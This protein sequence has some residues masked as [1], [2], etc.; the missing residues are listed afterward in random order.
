M[1]KPFKND[2]ASTSQQ[3]ESDV[4]GLIRKMHQQLVFLEKKIDILISH[5]QEKPF[6]EKPFSKPFRSFGRP[7]RTGYPQD[8]RAHDEGSRERNFPSGHHFEKRPGNEHRK[9]GGPQK[10]YSG[11]REDGSMHERHFKKKFGGPKKMFGHKKESFS[12]KRKE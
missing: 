4:L 7:Y 9:F 12:Y 10:S 1:T 8:K 6:R 3:A 2:N 5:S 11:D